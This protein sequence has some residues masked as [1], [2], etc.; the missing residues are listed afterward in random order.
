[1]DTYRPSV[2]LDLD[3]TLVDSVFHHVVAWDAA[4]RAGGYAVPTWRIH[5]AIGMGSDRLL[6]WL[7]GEHVGAADKLS[8]EHKRR[9]LEHA[10]ALHATPGALALVEDL[11][12]REV[13]F[14]VATS[15]STEE[16]QALLDALGT[17]DLPTAD[18]DS[19]E[20]AKP[21]PDLLLEAVAQIDRPIEHATMVG[22]SPW[23]AEA[24]R[25]VG[26][27]MVAVRCG[28]FGDRRLTDGGAATVVDDP[29]ALVGR[30]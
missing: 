29:R 23:D 11:R 6:P 9:F 26:V 5:E 14:V 2:L 28:G 8:D 18:A 19:V 17:H 4:L 3:G 13:P 1:M 25:M 22:D 7:L 10:D 15:A 21:A 27:R 20:A 16:L 24:A 30:L 12:H